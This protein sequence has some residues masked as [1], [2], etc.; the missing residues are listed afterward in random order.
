MIPALWTS[1][2]KGME[3]KE[4]QI[5][6]LW[7]L[8]LATTVSSLHSSGDCGEV[9][10][11]QGGGVGLCGRDTTTP[12]SAFYRERHK[13]VHW[14]MYQVLGGREEEQFTSP[15]LRNYSRHVPP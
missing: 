3:V 4:T 7:L 2:N 11:A 14:E 15:P 13:E 9:L 10:P 5:Q 8:S 12:H 1:L 6:G